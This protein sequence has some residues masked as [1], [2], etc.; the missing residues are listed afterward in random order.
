MTVAFV[1]KYLGI[2]DRQIAVSHAHRVKERQAV[3]VCNDI[4][5]PLGGSNI[6]RLGR[7]TVSSHRFYRWL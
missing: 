6:Y 1:L 7:F 3:E 4:N 2:T 5:P